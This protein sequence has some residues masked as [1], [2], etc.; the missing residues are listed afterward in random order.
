MTFQ[1][2]GAR[3]LR[4]ADLPSLNALC[5]TCNQEENLD[6]KLNWDM[7]HDRPPAEIN[8]FLCYHGSQLIGSAHLYSMLPTEAELSGMVHPAFRR[9]GVFR[10]LAQRAIEECR[11]RG[12]PQLLLIVDQNALS[13]KGFAQS[14]GAPYSFSEY[15]MELNRKKE[16]AI[17]PPSTA[18]NIELVLATGD[19]V[20]AM[21]RIDLAAFSHKQ[22]QLQDCVHFLQERM[23]DPH[24]ENYII[25]TS[26]QSVGKIHLSFQD[27][28][29]FIYGFAIHPEHQG[30]GYGRSALRRAVSHMLNKSRQPVQLEVACNNENALSLYHRCGFEKT[31]AY[32][33][34]RL[35]V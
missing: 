13:G 31:S 3:G 28:A 4:P 35:S 19:D 8:D 6:I 22:L 12:I 25:K 10:R 29:S 17:S 26:G 23:S 33:Y 18:N 30:R 32:D 5:K 7:L 27:D 34:Y 20:G 2:H 21:A 1:Y 14:T 16:A 9:Q 24:Y 15:K 11:E